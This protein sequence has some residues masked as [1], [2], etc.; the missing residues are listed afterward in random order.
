[1]ARL[2][3]VRAIALSALA[4]GLCATSQA[5]ADIV[6]FYTSQTAFHD[7]MLL[8]NK[9]NKGTEDFEHAIIAQGQK[10]PFPDFLTGGVPNNPVFPTGLMN[11]NLIL[12]TNR[13]PGPF[14]PVDAPSANPQALFALGAGAFGANSK[15]VGEDLGIL[16]GIH[17]SMDLI[18]PLSDKT[19]VGFDLSRFSGFGND[20]W[21]I[22]VFDSVGTL[23][24]S[25]TIVGPVSAN[26]AKNF[27]GIASSVP[28]GRINIYDPNATSPDA[29]DNIEMWAVP[30]PTSGAMLALGV[31]AMRRRRR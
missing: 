3:C 12:Q 9:F 26:P 15:K 22:G 17:C 7:A 14:A 2:H 30:A 11:D 18:F 20:G 19:G 25:Y 27:I 16:A 6:T 8:T 29:V 21:T 4:G 28:I 24:G 31:L 13:N 10:M 23:I 1:M 5:R